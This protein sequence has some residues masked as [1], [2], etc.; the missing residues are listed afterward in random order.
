MQGHL[1]PL[2]FLGEAVKRRN[3][4]QT[5]SS[6]AAGNFDQLLI[7]DIVESVDLQDL[8]TRKKGLGSWLLG[9]LVCQA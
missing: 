4:V 6:L 8:N 3:G 5:A 7:G 9:Q 2:T 1:V